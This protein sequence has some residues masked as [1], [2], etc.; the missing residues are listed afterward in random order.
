M[1]HISAVCVLHA[2]LPDP[3]DTGGMTAID[4]RAVPGRVAVGPLG[5][6]GDRQVD[7]EHHGG[8]DQ[9]VYLY[10][11]E[12]ADWWAAE[13]GRDI[14]PGLF[15]ENLRTSGLDVSG[16]RIGQR[17]RISGSGLLLEMTAPRIPCMT[18]GRRMDEAHWVKRF[19]QHRAP[20]AYARVVRSGGVGAGDAVDVLPMPAHDVTIAALLPP[21][22]PGAFARLLDAERAG[23][24]ELSARVRRKAMLAAAG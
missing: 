9:A 20:G 12:D 17:L 15:G 19:T 8:E 1:A 22:E 7:T 6:S 24:V 11:D 14:P 23:V 4:K 2:L 13:L 16:M 18:F 21:V 10:A 3:P 5:L